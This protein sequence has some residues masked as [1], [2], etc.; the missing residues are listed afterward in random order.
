[1]EKKIFGLF[2]CVLL[3]SPVI[4]ST[5]SLLEDLSYPTVSKSN[6][7]VFK[8]IWNETQKLLASD[9]Q[10]GDFFGQAVSLNG[11][12]V[13][14]GAPWDDDNG[15]DAGSAYIF[16]RSGTTWVQQAKLLASDGAPGDEFGFSV[17]L[18]G[19]TALIG[20]YM[21]D[22]DAGLQAGSVYVF[23]RSGV[24]W[25][26]EA[27]L[28]ASDG[29]ELAYFG[30]SVALDG[31]TAFIGA[32]VD[33]GTGAA[34]VFTRTGSSW[35]QK[36]KLVPSDAENGDAF[37]FSVSLNG[38]T[39]L[40]GALRDQNN[41]QET[42]SAYVYIYTGS[43]WIQQAKLI[44]SDGAGG[45][46][47]S[48]SVSLYG[49]TA[50]IGAPSDDDNGDD[51][52]SAYIFIRNDTTWVQEAKLFPS[53]GSAGDYFGSAVAFYNDYALIGAIGADTARGAVYVFKYSDTGWD[54]KIKLTASDGGA[55]DWFGRSI[56]FED[57]T[58]LIGAPVNAGQNGAV[59]TFIKQSEN[60]PPFCT[61]VY[62]IEHHINIGNI[63][64]GRFYTK[65]TW[66][67]GRPRLKVQAYDLDSGIDRVEFYLS[68]YT[69]I[70]NTSEGISNYVWSI[71]NNYLF[72]R[73]TFTAIAYNK[74]GLSTTVTLDGFWFT[75]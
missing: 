16:I 34:Y 18:Q 63:V 27:K 36:V 1:M 6:Q 70:T 11:D 35:T 3:I 33:G 56:S 55:G 67:V 71:K 2:M 69:F 30:V 37:G 8:D 39:A 38:G 59:Y 5:G 49:D 7:T 42:G 61:I 20:A 51:S 13:L 73:Y 58:A 28:E 75:F 24:T 43:T 65:L 50:L 48:Q 41:G 72:G 46:E 68:R 31:N 21:A 32:W 15:Q 40:I 22:T 17:T 57:S 66:V 10:S 74:D 44:A 4:A 60:Q 53:D 64:I 52:G 14:I 23:T 12:T 26:Q 19:D 25:T 45:D 62:P 47:F 54:Q 9:G 29:S